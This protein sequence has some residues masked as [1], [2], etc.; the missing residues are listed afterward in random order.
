[1][2]I[3]V[4]FSENHS[5]ELN[6]QI[7]NLVQPDLR[8]LTAYARFLELPLFAAKQSA[9]TEATN[10]VR[11]LDPTL[12]SGIAQI[13]AFKELDAPLQGFKKSSLL[14]MSKIL[15]AFA[16]KALKRS[17]ERG[18][19]YIHM[20]HVFFEDFGP[21][22]SVAK[23]TYYGH[24]AALTRYALKRV[25]DLTPHL[26]SNVDNVVANRTFRS[27]ILRNSSDDLSDAPYPTNV[28]KVEPHSLTKTT[29]DFTRC[30]VIDAEDPFIAF[31]WFAKRRHRT[32]SGVSP[33]LTQLEAVE[34]A[35]C[36]RFICHFAPDL[37]YERRGLAGR[38]QTTEFSADM[39]LSDG[40]LLNYPKPVFTNSRAKKREFDTAAADNKAAIA[41]R[42]KRLASTVF[43]PATFWAD[44]MAS[45]LDAA[46]KACIATQIITGCRPSEIVDGVVVSIL[47]PS[48]DSSQGRLHFL[49]F[50]A[51]LKTSP[52]V[53]GD[54]LSLAEEQYIQHLA[55]TSIA[56][57][58]KIRGQFYH[59]E[60]YEVLPQFPERVWLFE[61]LLGRSTT[62]IDADLAEAE[63]HLREKM[64]D[65]RRLPPESF[66]PVTKNSSPSPDG[67]VEP[68]D[69]FLDRETACIDKARRA[70]IASIV[71]PLQRMKSIRF[72]FLPHEATY[73]LV[74]RYDGV[75]FLA[76]KGSEKRTSA[77]QR[78]WLMNEFS[79]A[80][81]DWMQVPPAHRLSIPA[82]EYQALQ[83]ER[84]DYRHAAVTR[85]NERYRNVSRAEI[86]PTPYSARHR[87][88]S[89]LKG[90]TDENGQA[91]L[92][93]STLAQ[94]A[95]H[96]STASASG[97]GKRDYASKGSK[98]RGQGLKG[99]KGQLPV[100]NPSRANGQTALPQ[101]STKPSSPEPRYIP[102][103]S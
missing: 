60:T 3:E 12:V 69:R 96:A 76:D 103:D 7:G 18:G 34:L 23:S 102:K 68:F 85:F 27:L 37:K 21:G 15:D 99:I 53:K 77:R 64:R 91:L 78:I 88:M 10:L 28:D 38:G 39:L 55:A 79:Q 19:A 45:K 95:G 54:T 42:D 86:E 40:L 51:K 5:S 31:P 30:T 56:S 35:E 33:V 97:Y 16:K 48:A 87:M 92:T 22:Q 70:G 65:F 63:L 94:K 11:F 81:L 71:S 59:A 4:V 2:S 100:K 43:D 41:R 83:R 101:V 67:L 13:S 26:P 80:E 82:V 89:D 98:N 17:Q 58:A 57:N 32:R 36:L 49:I 74:A 25:T 93:R 52:V 84:A 9:E 44:V 29:L 66:T 72:R 24:R 75:P 1:M 46:T 61:Q 14:A 47:P 90:L 6:T 50:G 62:E 8:Q 20:T 73:P